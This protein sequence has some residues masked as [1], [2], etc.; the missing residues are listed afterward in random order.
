M[1]DVMIRPDM[2]TSSGEV[3][4]ILLHNKY[5][6]TCSIV[7]REGERIAGSVQ[8]EEQSLDRF[9]KDRVTS[10]VKTYIQSLIDALHVDECDVIVSYSDYDHVIA[11]EGNVGEIEEI[12]EVDEYFY[13]NDNEQVM[14]DFSDEDNESIQGYELMIVG[15]RKN[16]V[17]YHVYNED[18][19][20]IA[21]AFM[22][23]FGTDVVGEV[24]WLRDPTEDELNDVTELIISDFDDEEM[25]TFMIDMTYQDQLL[26]TLELTHEELLEDTE[27][28][29]TSEYADGDFNIVLT[30]DDNEILTYDIYRSLNQGELPFGR[31]TIDISELEVVGSIDVIDPGIPEE[32]EQIATSLMKEIDKVCDYNSFNLTMMYQ[33]K[34]I[35]EIMLENDQIH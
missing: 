19:Q 2:R 26:E 13:D 14:I 31:A 6:G 34:P 7:Y 8:L 35:D 5:V 33:N 15:E 25:D 18:K 12:I 28:T 27:Y 22:S 1:V 17:E 11:T 24:N 10:F 3:S 16:A 32:R 30:R 20:W 9:E 23:I 29:M 4:D 21:E